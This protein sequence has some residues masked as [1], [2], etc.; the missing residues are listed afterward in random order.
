[1]NNSARNA[2][3]ITK[4]VTKA[5]KHSMISSLCN[6]VYDHEKKLGGK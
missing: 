6:Q 5:E 4:Q 1:M 2:S 3:T